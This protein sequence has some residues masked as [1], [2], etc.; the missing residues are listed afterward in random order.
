MKK[1]ILWITVI[2]LALV[3]VCHDSVRLPWG[4]ESADGTAPDASA[5]SQPAAPQSTATED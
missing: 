5:T 1:V 3:I 4:L 2:L